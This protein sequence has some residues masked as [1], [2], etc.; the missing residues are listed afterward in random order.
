MRPK[1]AKDIIARDVEEETVLIT[2]DASRALVLNAIGGAILDLCDGTRT[3]EDIVDFI[4]NNVAVADAD[5]VHRDVAALVAQLIEA[6]VVEDLDP[7]GP[8]PSGS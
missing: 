7:C 2:P 8:P 3:V 4:C 5:E 1:R 6:G